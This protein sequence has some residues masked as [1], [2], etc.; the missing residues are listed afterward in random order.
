VT[1]DGINMAN[2]PEILKEADQLT[3][4]EVENMVP[5]ENGTDVEEAD[6]PKAKNKLDKLLHLGRRSGMLGCIIVHASIS[7]D[8]VFHIYWSSNFNVYV[9][10][11]NVSVFLECCWKVLVSMVDDKPWSE[12]GP[13][14]VH[15]EIF[16]YYRMEPGKYKGKNHYTSENGKYAIF[17]CD[18]T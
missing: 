18:G 4:E 9:I 11:S 7:V 12:N 2:H 17:W 5:E 14:K 13:Y 1:D 16:E 10:R 6:E 8:D 3:S 15:P